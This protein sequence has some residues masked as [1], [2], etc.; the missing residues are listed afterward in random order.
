MRVMQWPSSASLASR[1][2][3]EAIG[4]WALSTG[5]ETGI[6]VS[7][8]LVPFPRRADASRGVHVRRTLFRLGR[9]A[10]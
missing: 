5:V 2:A 8:I 6:L 3:V 4:Q 10:R 7:T 9:A 1:R